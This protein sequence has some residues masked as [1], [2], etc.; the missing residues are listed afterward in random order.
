M[1]NRARPTPLADVDVRWR[2]A[3][4]V[5]PGAYDRLLTLLFDDMSAMATTASQ[6]QPSGN[7]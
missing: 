6:D 7:R 5:T 3:D 2:P 4:E 1:P